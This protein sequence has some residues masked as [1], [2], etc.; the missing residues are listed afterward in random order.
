MKVIIIM[1]SRTHLIFWYFFGVFC[2]AFMLLKKAIID[3]VDLFLIITV[4]G[5]VGLLIGVLLGMRKRR[6]RKSIINQ[7]IDIK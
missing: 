3:W 4:W 5:S 2:G 6:N 7:D 1:K